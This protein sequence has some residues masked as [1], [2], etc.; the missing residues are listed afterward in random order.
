MKNLCAFL[1][2]MFAPVFGNLAEAQQLLTFD[3]LSPT[4]IPIL[5]SVVC[6]EGAG[7]RVVSDHFHLVGGT[8]VQDFSSNGTTHIGYESGRGLPMTLERF[9]GGT[10]S[11]YS[12]DAAEFYALPG[13]DR[14]DAEMLTIT[15]FQPGGGTVSYTVN[16][17]GI[18]DGAGGVDD[19]EH[20]VLPSTFVNLTAVVFTGLRAGDVSGGVAIDNIEYQLVAPE[21][22]GAC[23]ATPL[24]AE[25]PVVSVV[26]PL[27]GNVEG[28]VSVAATATDNLGIVSVQFKLDG[29]DLGPAD[30]TA[31]YSVSWDTTTVAD[32]PHTIT[33]EARD[34]ANNL[35]T[36]S[37]VVTVRN[38]PVVISNPSYLEFDG[39]DDYLLV[40]DADALSFGNGAADTPL[41]FEAWLRPD[42][43]TRH[44]LLGKWA[45][46][47]N[48]EYKLHIASGVI[49]LDLRDHSANA[50]V[51]AFTSSSQAPLIGSWHHV[52]VTYD[53]RGGPN[54]ANGITMYV[55][56]VSVPLTRLNSTA[57]VA[58]ENLSAPLQ[59]GREG[60]SWK[61][62]DGGLD[63]LRLWSIAR[64]AAE[65]QSTMTTELTGAEAGLVGYWTFSEGTG[66]TTADASP[67]HRSATLQNGTL[68]V[69]GGPLAPAVP[70]V[71]APA[72]TNVVTSNLTASGITI[73]FTTSEAATAWVAYTSAIACPCADV[74]SATAG[75]THV[76]TL[77]G[78]AGST[79]YQYEVRALDAAGNLGVGQTMT[80]TTLAPAVDLIPPSVSI[81]SPSA[82]TVRGSVL[83]QASASDNV[84]VLSV[85]FKLDGA[86]IGAPDTTAPYSI[87]WE[88]TAFG[89]GPHTLMAEA[90]DAMGNVGT[91]SVDVMT[92]NEPILDTPHY[93]EFD[94]VDDYLQAADSDALS[95]GNA[96]FDRPLTIEVWLRPDAMSRHQLLGKWADGSAEYKLHIAS[97][98]LRLDLRDQSAQALVS[99][100]TTGSQ[101]SLIGSWHHLAVTYDGRGGP[102]AADGITMYVDGVAVPLTRFNN[103][104]Y[105]AM[106]NL[107]A[108]LLIGRE[109]PSWKQFDGGLDELRLWSVAR[110]A[111]EIQ[112]T[113]TTEMGGFEPGLVGYWRF[114]EGSGAIVADDAGADNMA[115]VFNGAA[116]REGGPL[117]PAVPDLA[118]PQITGSVVSNVTD[119]SATIAFNTSEA[120]TGWVAY[121]A[122]GA[123]P[124]PEVYSAALGTT[125]VVALSGLTPATTY[126]FLVRATDAAGNL[127]TAAAMSFTTLALQPDT[128]APAVVLVRPT[129]GNIAGTVLVEATATDTRGVVSVQFT[130]DGTPVG[131]ARTSTPYTLSLDTTTLSD[132]AHTIAA[133]ARDA[134]NNVG[135]ASVVVTVR[136]NV[137]VTPHYLDLDGVDD[138]AQ[139]ADADALSFGNGVV[140]TPLTMEMWFRPDAM[141]RHQLLGKW[142]DGSNGEY[143]LHIASG[144][145]R[146]D[147]RD[148][149]ANAVVSA[150]TAS[151][152][153]SLIGSWHHL[154]VTYDGRGGATAANGITIYVDGVPVPLTRFNNA[155]YVA[156][157]NQ[158][159]PLQIGR[160]GPSWK[161]YDGG[162]DELRL[163][164]V[165]RTAAE[166][167]STLTT[168]LGSLEPGLVGYWPFNEG[169]GVTAADGS[170][171]GQ[172]ATLVNGAAWLA[173]GPM[174]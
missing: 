173:G 30:T 36:A 38:Y 114:N 69:P 44:Q 48:A 45:D 153:A 70:D 13:S 56:G 104:T 89:D 91:A 147:L 15:G 2:C 93:L 133:E 150:F 137:V 24:V 9:G 37:L 64:T 164:N 3:E 21:V 106:E 126:Q 16:I 125:H 8:L 85:Q 52:A 40:A 151:S 74:Y 111:A 32:G 169:T 68:W 160:E 165:A 123:C 127:Q 109:G 6:G 27:A 75:T 128:T 152:H 35:G 139:V 119:S 90:R 135:T 159:A 157:E 158:N 17:D 23:V 103:A 95:F 46:G 124:C 65:I 142:S 31:P 168:E 122:T 14:P 67:A 18:H 53:G 116:W 113:M 22:L 77:S 58:M 10:F 55:D 4:T 63:E 28:T 76:V 108:P 171:E 66:A 118:P 105:V 84:A 163:W 140:D 57:Y 62:Y 162:L 12:F 73:A 61:Q 155:A 96:A 117:A 132:G 110:T 131:A 112:S 88:T 80:F 20:F 143:K 161:Q 94:G 19:F 86:N 146:V 81:S 120:A 101:V 83:V 170:G 99:A 1:L 97:G 174:P 82:G 50:V 87:S 148:H 71:T 149:S 49:R 5:G 51:S 166:I 29:V 11:L 154:A 167:Q 102:T 107:S 134:A 60:P 39:V 72:I 130:V 42:S 54:A 145:I 100:F 34:A 33:A 129:A 25:T 7:F 141:S 41:T 98:V 156:M 115:T 172:A 59:V 92:S 78:L 121:T 138:Y 43:M 136:N 47:P 144:V 79:Q 26:S